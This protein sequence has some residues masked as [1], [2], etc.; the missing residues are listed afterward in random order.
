M[1]EPA[2]TQV[3]TWEGQEGST[4]QSC[5]RK[6]TT[7]AHDSSPARHLYFCNKPTAKPLTLQRYEAVGAHWLCHFTQTPPEHKGACRPDPRGSFPNFHSIYHRAGR[8]QGKYSLYH[9]RSIFTPP[10]SALP[11][12]GPQADSWSSPQTAGSRG[13]APEGNRL[14]QQNHV[15][16]RALT[17][18]TATQVQVTAQHV[19]CFAW[20]A[21]C[22]LGEEW[23][24][25]SSSQSTHRGKTTSRD[26]LVFSQ[27]HSECSVGHSGHFGIVPADHL[28]SSKHCLQMH[29]LQGTNTNSQVSTHT[30]R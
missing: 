19:M 5:P 2:R 30:S 25:H 3:G 9:G 16:Q 13:Q 21:A 27:H 18:S 24:S 12:A 20:H 14:R 23:A 17:R 29:R 1:Q 8:E 22:L 26:L 4:T 11:P 15:P 7:P 28:S 10:S 6:D